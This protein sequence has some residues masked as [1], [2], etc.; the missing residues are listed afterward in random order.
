MKKTDHKFQ[1]EQYLKRRKSDL[2]K[3]LRA[4][5]GFMKKPKGSKTPLEKGPKPRP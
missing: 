3:P 1:L 4:P 5:S 2:D